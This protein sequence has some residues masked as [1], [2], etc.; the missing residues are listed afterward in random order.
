M[1]KETDDRERAGTVEMIRESK[2][3]LF[4]QNHPV[5]RE[6]REIPELL[7]EERLSLL[8]TS[9]LSLKN[10]F[11]RKQMDYYHVDCLVLEKIALR[12]TQILEAVSK[13]NVFPGLIGL[14]DLFVDMNCNQYTVYLLRP[15]KFQLLHFEQDYEWYPEDE[16]IF[17]ELTLF[18]RE[19][20]LKAD[21]RLIYKILVA[22]TK[23]N[24]KIPP[25]MSEADYS[26]LFYKALPDN[27][28]ELFE[29]GEACGYA[30]MKAMLEQS[31]HLEEEF[32][33]EAKKRLDDKAKHEL[34][35]Q[36]KEDGAKTG[37]K[38]KNGNEGE[39]ISLFLILRTEARDS[40]KISKMLYLLQDDLEM[41]GSLSGK[42][43]RQSFVFG[44]GV[45]MVKDFEIYPPGFRCQFQ[46]EIKEYSAG[47]AL[48]IGAD[49]METAMRTYVGADKEYRL[50]L[51][52]D[53]RLKNDRL[54]QS[55]LEKLKE[56]IK[57]G[58]KV[59]FAADENSQ[60]EACEKL[61][62]LT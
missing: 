18:T 29:S 9:A 41:D 58:W 4:L 60:C 37:Q 36:T 47:E 28:K 48:I 54:F 56:C 22:S 40:R 10:L 39:I 2:K 42:N 44:N 57:K 12:V 3:D 46:Q 20:Q 25:K 33:K 50:Y 49:M 15:E 14:E 1:H 19:D 34:E 5:V 13:K 59:I 23:G 45:V 7:F 62:N 32:A 21:T 27:F 52:T 16:R 24:V 61:R 31:I 35:S 8:P 38:K 51:L 53:G 30:R 55:A 43:C 17:G 6:L 11:T 26:E